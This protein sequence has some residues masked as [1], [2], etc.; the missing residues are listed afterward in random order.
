MEPVPGSERQ[1]PQQY[2]PEDD[3]GS[4]FDEG[5]EDPDLWENEEGN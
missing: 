1:Q 4:R 3:Y 5:S 2:D